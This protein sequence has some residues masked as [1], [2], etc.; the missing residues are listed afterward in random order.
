[1]RPREHPGSGVQD[2]ADRLHESAG[3][4]L[5][6]A[7]YLLATPWVHQRVVI[8]EKEDIRGCQVDRLIPLSSARRRSACTYSHRMSGAAEAISRVRTF[9]LLRQSWLASTT[10]IS[11]GRRDCAS[12]AGDTLP[13][14]LG[15]YRWGCRATSL[16]FFPLPEGACRHAWC[17]YS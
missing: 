10:M 1:M 2:G 8:E 12:G 9:W 15:V 6:D 5:V 4:R 16:A 3:V 7:H 17:R 14:R 13:G 11:A